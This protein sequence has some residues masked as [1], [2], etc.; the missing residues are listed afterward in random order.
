MKQTL[1]N[2]VIHLVGGP[3]EY[4]GRVEVYD[5]VSNQWGTICSSDVIN[6]YHVAR[7]VCSTFGVSYHA[8]GPASLSSNIQPSINSPI[9]NGHIDC[10]SNYNYFYQCPSFPLNS[11]EAMSRCTP[12]NEWVVACHCK[13]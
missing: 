13:L 4:M 9:V 10:H 5:R 12:D 2:P 7:L 8:Y 6:P 1:G 11:T 3:V